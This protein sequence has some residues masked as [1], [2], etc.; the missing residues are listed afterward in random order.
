VN[1]QLIAVTDEVNQQK[2]DKGP[3][4]WQP[5]EGNFIKLVIQLVY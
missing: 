4:E 2:G 5:S 1:P 3:E